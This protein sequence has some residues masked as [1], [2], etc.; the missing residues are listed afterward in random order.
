MKSIVLRISETNN[1]EA[2]ESSAVEKSSG[3][4]LQLLD[5]HGTVLAHEPIPAN[6][7]PP[8][9]SDDYT[10]YR[11]F[12][13]EEE[14]EN[15]RFSE[16]GMHLFALLH[17]GDVG[18]E[19]DRLARTERHRVLLDIETSAMGPRNIARLPWELI[20]DG[21]NR[22]FQ[23]MDAPIVRIRNYNYEE[24]PEVEAINWP[25]RLLIVVGANDRPIAA[26]EEVERIEDALHNVN[27]LIDVETLET[28]DI[29]E[30]R[31]K[32]KSFKPHIF[33]YIGHGGMV[34]ENSYIRLRGGPS[35]DDTWTAAQIKSGPPTWPWIPRFAFINA[36][37]T[38]GGVATSDH[39]AAWGIS[40][41]FNW[42][43]V[44]AVLTMQANIDGKLASRFAGTLYEHLAQGHCIDRA[45]A[46]ARTYLRDNSNAINKDNKRE[47]ATPTLTICLPPEKILPLKDKT[48]HSHKPAVKACAKFRE[49][50]L[51]AN[52][53]KERRK[54]IYG[55]YPIR[56][57]ELEKNL[58]L[59][60][61][62]SASG[63]TWVTLWC[64]EA[65]ALLDHNVRHVEVVSGSS[66]KWL[67][68][69]RQIQAGDAT[70][71]VG[72]KLI[73]GPLR[74]E[75]FYEFN[76]ELH[77]RIRNRTPLPWDQNKFDFEEDLDLT[78]LDNLPLDMV[79]NVF[80]AFR[81]ALL[82]AAE[83]N[84]PLIIVLD[85]WSYKGLRIAPGH[86]E[87]FLIPFL[88]KKAA[89][90]DLCAP[91]GRSVKLVLV[92]N[93]EELDEMYPELMSQLKGAFHEVHLQGIKG[94]LFAKVAKEFFRNLRTA[95]TSGIRNYA[96]DLDDEDEDFFIKNFGK[97]VHPV[98]QPSR[99]G[100]IL[101][102]VEK[103]YARTRSRRTGPRSYS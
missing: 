24:G 54:F 86:M 71:A 23:D 82:E 78:E 13:L 80:T 25:I 81:K 68:V 30:L 11:Q 53:K 85:Q 41:A 6:L 20:F 69:L 4:V 96:Q 29:N 19:W 60:R 34:E 59:V 28:P 37:R 35:G 48:S 95:G 77:Y 9:F 61:G 57:P 102:V 63:K 7:N 43:R 38:S 83:P 72:D 52:C 5:D 42:L 65:C 10:R 2:D 22:C 99:L 55:F 101:Y 87:K 75:A 8:S 98:W 12:F 3:L 33:H 91:D 39:L 45:L 74:E 90:G 88:F 64:L 97:D 92:M 67:H 100:D 84:N 50:D 27:R 40:D 44:P 16:I 15:G 62:C 1:P 49:V 79:K 32:C 14:N 66:P 73:Y 31:E 18:D 47:W 36:C 51:L 103:M 46:I 76:Y 70:K 89:D 94:A 58:V 93:D 26:N 17:L 56:R 21:T